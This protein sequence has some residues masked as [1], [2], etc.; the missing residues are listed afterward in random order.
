MKAHRLLAG[1]VGA[2]CIGGSTTAAG[3]DSRVTTTVYVGRHFEVR[4]HDQPVK[5]VFNGD[6]RVARITGSLS[7]GTRI[8]RLRLRSGWN[9]VSFAVTAT[10][11]LQQLSAPGGPDEG[12]IQSA[13]LWTPATTNYT[14]VLAGQTVS[15]GSVL[16]IKATTNKVVGIGGA[17]SDP[18]TPSVPV[19]G[20]YVS[21][22]GLESWNLQ[23]PADV[24]VWK[25]DSATQ[26]WQAGFAGD[27]SPV[28][29]LPPNLAPGEAIYVHTGAPVELSVPDPSLRVAYY[30]PDHLGSSS[31]VTDAGGAVVEETAYYPFGATR[32]EERLR[33]IET[34]YGFS[35]KE[36]DAESGLQYFGQ[37]YHHPVIG[38]WIST[39][40]LGEK[41]GGFNPYAYVKQSP[42]KHHDPNGAEIMV[43]EIVDKKARTTTYEI[44]LKAAVIDTSS[45]KIK[46]QD[47]AAFAGKLKSSIEKSYSGE[48][49]DKVDGKQWNYKWTT[50][51]DLRVINDWKQVEKDDHVFQISDFYRR[52]GR[53][54]AAVGGM[55]INLNASI[56]KRSGADRRPEETGAHELGHTGGL[57]HKN[58]SRNLMMEGSLRPDG[59]NNIGLDQI[60]TI[61]K[62]SSEGRLNQ[63]D[64]V[65]YELD[66]VAKPK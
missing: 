62:A 2:A 44:S 17:Y 45:E 54:D 16:W 58:S 27:L 51:V 13:Y 48:G 36:R 21:G 52:S 10:N 64:K 42:L 35:Q 65:M 26:L 59:A 19:G 23:L 20:S 61:W 28:S 37:R 14:S 32:N 56:F 43:V 11:A 5:Y 39:D 3:Q 63:R 33:A 34:H 22:N 41:G 6:T 9:L 8:Q 49:R 50:S 38:R 60:Q 66:E 46:Q 4:D 1:I 18:T 29:D 12:N 25:F 57:E 15:A 55:L 31:V 7:Q 30:H 53:A 47:L 24:T 40:P